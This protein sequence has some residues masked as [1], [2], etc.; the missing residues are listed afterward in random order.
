MRKRKSF[1]FLQ[2]DQWIDLNIYVNS[3]GLDGW[4]I[5]SSSNVLICD[6]L[7]ENVSVCRKCGAV[8]YRPIS[9]NLCKSCLDFLRD[10]LYREGEE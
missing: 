8:P 9:E 7:E 3:Y 5:S 6:D 10:K 1:K 4:P 2:R